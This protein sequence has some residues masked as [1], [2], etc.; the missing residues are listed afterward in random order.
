MVGRLGEDQ[1][2]DYARRK[3]MSVEEAER[4]LLQELVEQVLG[5]PAAI[6]RHIAEIDDVAGERERTILNMCF[7]AMS[8]QQS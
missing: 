5:R 1:V 2:T 3:G 4:W 6:E 8:G 7:S